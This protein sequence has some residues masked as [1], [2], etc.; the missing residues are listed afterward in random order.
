MSKV[1]TV[2][3]ALLDAGYEAEFAHTGGGCYALRVVLGD[4]TADDFSEVLVTD[5][6]VFS[7]RDFDSDDELTGEWWIGAYRASGDPLSDELRVVEE[8]DS[9]AT[10]V[11]AVV[12]AVRAAV[13]DLEADAY[14]SL[15]AA[16]GSGF[17]PDTRGNDY[18]T[19]P[20]GITA[21]DVD[22]IIDAA[23]AAGLDVY[24]VALD[25]ITKGD[26]S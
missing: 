20:A 23:H 26:A 3:S 5:S 24:S 21:R 25:I 7:I 12:A 4:N 9:F 2:L 8:V 6:D 22:R 14:R 10:T 11:L 1:Q 19:L 17:H 16:V 13:R 15:V 18:S